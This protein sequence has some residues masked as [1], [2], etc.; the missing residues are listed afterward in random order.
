M[1]VAPRGKVSTIGNQNTKEE[2]AMKSDRHK[3]ISA[4]SNL[5]QFRSLHRSIVAKNAFK[6]IRIFIATAGSLRTELTIDVNGYD[7]I[8]KAGWRCDRRSFVSVLNIE[9][10]TRKT[11]ESNHLSK[12]S[13]RK[14]GPSSKAE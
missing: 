12:F 7:K 11:S 6:D 3:K 10:T 14:N 5:N 2:E 8:G 13:I 4:K 9:E 1:E